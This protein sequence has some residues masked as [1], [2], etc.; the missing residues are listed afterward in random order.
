MSRAFI[1]EQDGDSFEPLPDRP[2]SAH[3]NNVTPAGVVQ[4]EAKI[5]V[6]QEAFSRAQASGDRGAMAIA[7]RE[8]RYWNIRR[9]SAQVIESSPPDGKVHFGSSVTIVRDDGRRQTFRIVGED[10]AD[11]SNGTVS[12]ISPLARALFGKSVGDVGAVAGR[13]IEILAVT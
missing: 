7:A 12:H 2:V 5:Q 4:I 9:A 11:P 8:L 10:E 6:E 1:R 13:E 3:P